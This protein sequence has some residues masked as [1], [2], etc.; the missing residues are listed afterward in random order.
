MKPKSL[1]LKYLP[2]LKKKHKLINM[3]CDIWVGGIFILSQ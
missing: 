1:E 3:Q 2:I